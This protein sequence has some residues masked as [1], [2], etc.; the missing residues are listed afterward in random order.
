LNHHRLRP[1]GNLSPQ[2]MDTTVM[3]HIVVAQTGQVTENGSGFTK[4]MTR[5]PIYEVR[6]YW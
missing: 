2:P 6:T 4:K 1:D 5:P 3:K